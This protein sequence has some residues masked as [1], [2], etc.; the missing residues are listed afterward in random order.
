MEEA[1]CFRSSH[2]GFRAHVTTTYT[3]IAEITESS[4]PVTSNRMITLTT[5]LGILEDKKTVLRE[6]DAKIIEAIQEPGQLEE[7][8]CE[9]EEYDAVVTEKIAFLRDF[10]TRT[11]PPP[12]DT[13]HPPHLQ[14]RTQLV[15]VQMFIPQ[16]LHHNRKMIMK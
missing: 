14:K 5:S 2:G 13:V 12:S 7:E 8:I 16:T 6:L 1:S 4:E 15:Q 9:T 10:M 3:R 11:H